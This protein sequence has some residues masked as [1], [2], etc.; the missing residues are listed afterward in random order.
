ME[1]DEVH[2]AASEAVG[3]ARGGEGP[4]LIEA[5]TY[6]YLGH[7]KSDANLYRTRD[8]I[9]QWREQDPI[10]RL[11]MKLEDEG[12]L[13]SEEWRS[14]ERSAKEE[15]EESFERAAREP[16]PEPASALEDLYA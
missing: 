14:L 10:G 4:T 15:I 8:E 13:E 2:E 1:L 3:R 6:R 5:V 7:S 12:V 11:A 16:E 9:V